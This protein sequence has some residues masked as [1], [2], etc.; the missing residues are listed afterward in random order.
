MV[1]DRCPQ[2]RQAGKSFQ[3]TACRSWASTELQ[4]KFEVLLTDNLNHEGTKY[5]RA[6]DLLVEGLERGLERFASL[7]RARVRLAVG[8]PRRGWN[9]INNMNTSVEVE[10]IA[11]DQDAHCKLVPL[12]PVCGAARP[13]RNRRC[14]ARQERRRLGSSDSPPGS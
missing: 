8:R 13:G 1:L 6:N 3:D 7:S 5:S 10:A 2:R 11:Q 14:C 4:E 9:F 12:P